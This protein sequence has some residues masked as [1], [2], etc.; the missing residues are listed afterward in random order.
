MARDE[1]AVLRRVT[2]AA[3]AA[4]LIVNGAMPYSASPIPG[5]TWVLIEGSV[6]SWY[7]VLGDAAVLWGP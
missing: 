6:A 2:I 4:A 7:R 5:S 3:L 1:L